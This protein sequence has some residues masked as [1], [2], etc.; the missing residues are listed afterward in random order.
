MIEKYLDNTNDLLNILLL[1][2]RFSP[3]P[4]S[5][6]NAL[7]NSLL[8]LQWATF[9]FNK[10]QP[11]KIFFPISP[12]DLLGYCLYC[13]AKYQKIDIAIVKV[14]WNINDKKGFI[15]NNIYDLD[16]PNF[17]LSGNDFH[18]NKDVSDSFE[19]IKNNI[20]KYLAPT[21]NLS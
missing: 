14:L 5:I 2:Q 8:A 19:S 13:V 3:E 10:Y 1:S 11:N 12:H 9:I 6:N 17:T 4:L 16:I 18:I 7:S 15:M 20:Q 21:Y